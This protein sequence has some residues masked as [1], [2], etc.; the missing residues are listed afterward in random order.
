[1][2]KTTALALG[3]LLCGAFAYT[4]GSIAPRQSSDGGQSAATGVP[5]EDLVFIGTVIKIYPVASLYSRRNWAVVTHIDKVVSGE[6]SGATLTFTVHSPARMGLRLSRTYIIK[7][8]R[9]EGG[10]LVD[11]TK[12]L[13]PVAS[14]AQTP[15]NHSSLRGRR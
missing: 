8:M 3:F 7:A 10:Y 4:L 15:P 11:D 14:Q 12:W 6:F 1:M 2:R 9:S 13:K 5:A